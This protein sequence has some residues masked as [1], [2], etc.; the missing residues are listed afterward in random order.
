MIKVLSLCDGI[1]IGLAAFKRLGV[2]VEYHAIEINPDK[3]RIADDNHAGIIRPGHD[4]YDFILSEHYDFIIAGPTCTS[5]SSQ[6]PR[7]DWD[8]ESKVFFACLD[9]LR[10]GQAINP[11]LKFFF[12]NV[13]SM[14]NICRDRITFELGVDPFLGLSA[15]VSGQDRK[16]YYWFNWKNPEIKDRGIMAD[17]C[18]DNDGLLLVAFSKSNRNEVGQ[19]S[20][21]EGRFKDNGKSATLVTGNGCTGQSTMNKV[22]TKNMTVRNLSVKECA[23]LQSIPEY[24][25]AC[26]DAKAYEAIGDGWSCA[27]VVEILRAVL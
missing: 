6:G 10:A 18:L 22:F 1:A 12:E 25:F 21:V 19:P 11:E 15:L 17:N 9:I 4:V 3:R 5:L 7:T 14:K 27:M 16:R 24:V 13:H 20:I 2:E 23:R 26:S 8:G